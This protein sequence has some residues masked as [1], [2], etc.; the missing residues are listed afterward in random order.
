MALATLATA[1]DLDTKGVCVTDTAL[2]DLM[3]NA[4]SWIIRDAAGSVISQV[5]STIKVTAPAGRWLTLPGPVTAVAEVKV[6][7]DVVTDAKLLNGML[8]R[9]CGWQP[10]GDPVEVEVTLTH[11]YA[12]VPADI[13]NLCADLAKL[14]IQSAGQ[15]AT[16]ANVV[17]VSYSIDD[18]TERLQYSEDARTAME[19]PE[20]TR[21]W[22][23]QRFGTG[24]YVTGELR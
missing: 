5:T 16:P 24:V 4:A 3:L 2:V 20:V 14:G 9:A 1:A 10:W 7:D 23:A 6:D 8:F 18:Y 13:V 12:E 11:G 22:L 21:Q 15:A 17:S 19:L